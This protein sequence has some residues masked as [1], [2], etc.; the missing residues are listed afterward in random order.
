[1]AFLEE[2]SQFGDLRSAFQPFLSSPHPWKNLDFQQSF[3][4]EFKPFQ[5]QSQSL[6][7]YPLTLAD[8]LGSMRILLENTAPW[9]ATRLTSHS[10]KESGEEGLVTPERGE[11]ANELTEVL[12]KRGESIVERKEIELESEKVK[13]ITAQ[14]PDIACKD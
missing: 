7:H 12:K 6:N 3:L 1:M 14:R 2:R 5:Y 9:G 8:F 13:N 4:L 11:R 10:S